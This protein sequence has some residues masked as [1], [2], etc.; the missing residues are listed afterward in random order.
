M[1]EIAKNFIGG[2]WVEGSK[3]AEDINP[4]DTNEVVVRFVQADAAQARGAIAA[5]KDAFP[6]WSRSAI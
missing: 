4:S 5:A 6:A 2:T 1:N 3:V